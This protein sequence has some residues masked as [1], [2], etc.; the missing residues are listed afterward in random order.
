MKITIL[1]KNNNYS[2]EVTPETQIRE[3]RKII[4]KEI[5]L[6]WCRQRHE[7]QVD[8]KK[9][10]L[11]VDKYIKDYEIKEGTEV[12][13]KDLGKQL[14]FRYVYIWEYTGPL[15][16]YVL[17]FIFALL[18]GQQL[19]LVHYCALLMWVIHYV[20]RILETIFIH[21]FG[22]MTMPVFNIYKNCTYYWGFGLAVGINVNFFKGEVCH[23]MIFAGLILAFIAMACNGYC[24]Y[25]LKCLRRKGTQE[26]LIP[27]G[28]LFE[29]ITCPNYFCEIMTWFFFRYRIN[30][31]TC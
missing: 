19:Y 6:E 12:F 7:L 13:M 31:A 16:L 17:T 3:L 20:K 26:W 23:I 14:P 18:S 24:H 15:V 9:V 27:H 2:I 5:G 4:E 29:Y 11:E 10:V 21:E 22:D 8:G 25:L 30:T 28:F 1:Y